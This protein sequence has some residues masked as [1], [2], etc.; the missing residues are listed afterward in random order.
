MTLSNNKKSKERKKTAALYARVSTLDQHPE[1]QLETLRNYAKTRDYDVYDEYVDRISGAKKSR[2][3]LNRLM[4]DA[5]NHKFNVVV[6]WK[7]DRLGRS[8]K[9]LYQIIGEW[10]NLGIDFI[11]T[12]LGVDTATPAGK[13]V[14][15]V[16]AQIAEFEREIIRERIQLGINQRKKS[17]EK[18][19]YYI[20]SNGE[21]K[22]SL[23]RPKGKKD[24][25]G[26]RRKSGY[27]RRWEKERGK[28]ST[29]HKN[30][31]NHK[32]KE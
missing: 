20:N 2:P 13:L 32:E 31:K 18:Q 21:R 30:S 29:P 1:N 5:R 10:D 8:T 25:K 9:H 22:T 26:R 14:F 24:S 16:M 15:G 3:D 28:K 11:L 6:V 17:I 23:G 12:T 4:I 7:I 27:Y 19:G